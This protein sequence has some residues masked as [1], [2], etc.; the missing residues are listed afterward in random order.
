MSINNLPIQSTIDAVMP[1]K[2]LSKMIFD[3]YYLSPLELDNELIIKLCKKM[4]KKTK[5]ELK[6]LLKCVDV[7]LSVP[8]NFFKLSVSP[9]YSTNTINEIRLDFSIRVVGDETWY[10]QYLYVDRTT[11]NLNFELSIGYDSDNDK[12]IFEK[13]NLCNLSDKRL[14]YKDKFIDNFDDNAI[15]VVSEYY[16]YPSS[17]SDSSDS[18][19]SE[20][21]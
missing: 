14:T 19:D 5:N 3:Y 6:I 21:D 1:V 9:L 7:P 18:S 17:S 11:G 15:D 10:V 2:V 4:E 12:M 20:S 8:K 16:I 13:N